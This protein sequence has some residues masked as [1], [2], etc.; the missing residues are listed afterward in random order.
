MKSRILRILRTSAL[1]L[2]ASEGVATSFTIERLQDQPGTPVSTTLSRIQTYLDQYRTDLTVIIADERSVQ[3]INGQLPIAKQMPGTR[4]TTSEVHF[5]FV[6]GEGAWMA[7]REVRTVDGAPVNLG[8]DLTGA[9]QKQQVGQVAATF[10]ALNSQFNIGRTVRTFNEPTL[11]LG[12]FEPSR[13]GSFHFVFKNARVEK[14][15]T[16]VS[17]A[18]KETLSSSPFI[19]NHEMKGVAVEGE[20]QVEADSGRVRRTV[21]KARVDSVR[22]ELI[23]MYAHN[24][25]LGLWVPVTFREHYEHGIQLTGNDN[26]TQGVP[27]EDISCESKYTNFRRFAAT[28]RIK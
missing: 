21:L 25:K 5:R 28:A 19:L 14:G 12:I 26:A 27:Y 4:T 9:L 15:I 16:L 8:T 2:A 13:V 18:F 23:T 20:V 7:I 10:K 22:A 11:A 3:R 6:R 1:V 17:L 24:A